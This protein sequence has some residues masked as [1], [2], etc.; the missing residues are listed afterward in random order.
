M[1]QI[2]FFVIKL[3]EKKTYESLASYGKYFFSLYSITL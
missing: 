3:E 1:L 2:N